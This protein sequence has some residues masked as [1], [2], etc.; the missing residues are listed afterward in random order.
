MLIQCP[1]CGHPGKVSDKLRPI[2]QTARCRKCGGKFTLLPVAINGPSV[3]DPM[4]YDPSFSLDEQNQVEAGRFFSGADDDMDFGSRALS[5]GDSHYEMSAVYDDGYDDSDGEIPA[6][7]PGESAE[8]VAVL[9]PTFEAEGAEIVAPRPWY[10]KFLESW[11]RFQLL[12]ALGFTAASLSVLGFLLLRA[13]AGGQILSASITALVLG[14]VGTIA[15]LLLSLSATALTVL[16]VDLVRNVRQLVQHAERSA[17]VPQEPPARKRQK[18][19][20][21]VA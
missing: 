14:C 21:P 20:H 5:A 15:F 17:A 18:L 12:T 1:K 8:N 2:A 19:S 16:L 9:F 10:F 7:A 11:G 13:L 6:F 4:P 3:R